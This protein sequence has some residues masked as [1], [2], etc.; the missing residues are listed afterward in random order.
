MRVEGKRAQGAGD[1]ARRRRADWAALGDGVFDVL[2]VG[3]G[4]VGAGIALQAAARGLRVALVEAADF[5][6]GSSSRSTKL[7]HGGVRY[8]ERA[9]T[10]LD[11]AEFALVRE[12]LH[13]RAAF[14]RLAPFLSRR[15]A[16]LTPAYSR[17]SQLYLAAGLAL[18]DLLAGPASLGRTRA[19]CAAE[20]T[21]TFSALGTR[22]LRGAVLYYDGQFDD[23]RLNVLLALTAASLGA[24]VCNYA[25][26]CAL[27]KER[28][29]LAGAAVVDERDG[30]EVTVR[31]RAV[32]NAAGP[33][34][35]E[36]R[37]LDDPAREPLLTTSSGVHLVVGGGLCPPDTGLLIPQTADGRLIFVLPWLGHT[38]IG[39]TDRAAAAA[40][41]PA[42]E[43]ADVDYLLAHVNRYL[44]R[45]LAA[46]DVLSA[47]SGLRPLVRD[48]Q[49]QGT[50]ALARSHVV[51]ES[52]SG[53][54][55]VLGGKWTTYR[56]IAAD[57]IAHLVRHHGLRAG[58]RSQ[59]EEVAILGAAGYTPALPREVGRAH[60]LEDDVAEHLGQSYGAQMAGVAGLAAE[61]DTARL[62]GGLPYLEAEVLWAVRVERA[63]RVMDVLARRLRLAFLDRA[64]A[65]RAV[66]RVAALMAGDLGW[67]AQRRA[68]E[69]AA[70]LEELRT[71]I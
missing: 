61:D 68:A 16:I 57:A 66:P 35:D 18:Y 15:L 46:A 11:R 67:D 12:A 37:A 43:A 42:V 54:V 41:R 33:F 70:A 6:S 53:L 48:P 34:G 28:G 1:A 7:I 55:S 40:A 30:G 56:R 58:P 44:A 32:V 5:A 22:G 71:A 4:S 36:V 39:T 10:H 64:A 31:A 14:F 45:P 23:A 52:P 19:L 38:L 20:A 2:I 25:R 29:R 13:E 17:G 47:W 69:E 65:E 59:G 27:V 9:V 62:A 26:V 21:R 8:L 3:G 63:Q 50:A 49:R 51:V 24:V 60:H